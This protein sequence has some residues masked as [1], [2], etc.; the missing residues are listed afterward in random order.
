MKPDFIL[1][2]QKPF[3]LSPKEEAAVDAFI[4]ENLKKGFIIPSKSEQA[5]ALFFVSK[6][7]ESLCPVQDYYYLN[8]NTIPN[9]YPLPCID[10]TINDLHEFD[11]FHKFDVCWGYN[12]IKI[13]D[14]DQ[15]KVAFICKQGLFE[16][17]VM[18]FGLRNSPATFQSMINEIFKE[19]ITQE[20][21]WTIS[22]SVVKKQTMQSLQIEDVVFF[23]DFW[24]TIFLSNWI[25]VSFSWKQSLSLGS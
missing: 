7:D 24:N 16:P 13:K 10:D 4:D 3:R 12:N 18:Y 20:C 11:F 25:K 8:Q 9:A 23:N 15:W 14:G 19:E 5:S 6:T 22:L 17:Q 2:I 21:I 1:K